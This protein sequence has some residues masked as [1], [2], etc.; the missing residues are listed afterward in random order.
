M[1]TC[2]NELLNHKVAVGF[3]DSGKRIDG[4]LIE[5][6]AD[7]IVVQQ[8]SFKYHCALEH[9]EFIR[10]EGIAEQRANTDDL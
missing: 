4:I 6:Q 8:P 2:T 9:V 3:A 7:I 1:K 10:D 5:I